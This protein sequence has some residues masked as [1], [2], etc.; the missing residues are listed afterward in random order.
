MINVGGE[1]VV[2][3]EIEKIVKALPGI[4]EAIAI[5]VTHKLFGQ[6]EKLF[7][8]KSPGSTIQKSEIISYCVKNLERYKVPTQIEFIDEIPRTEYGKIKRFKLE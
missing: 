3:E 4:T 5:E 7:V 8:Q 6:V 1:K 2:P